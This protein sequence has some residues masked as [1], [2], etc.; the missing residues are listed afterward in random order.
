[1]VAFVVYFLLSGCVRLE[2]SNYGSLART[3]HCKPARNYE[4][5]WRNVWPMKY[6]TRAVTEM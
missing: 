5:A 6:V 3:E 4:T 2:D 1:M